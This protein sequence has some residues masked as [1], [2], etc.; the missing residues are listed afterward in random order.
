MLEKFATL[1]SA[2]SVLKIIILERFST[3]GIEISSKTA[4]ETFY[5]DGKNTSIA[6]KYVATYVCVYIYSGTFI[7]FL[8]IRLACDV[9]PCNRLPS[10][11]IDF[12]SQS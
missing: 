5:F 11:T 1:L 9:T 6:E 4:V 10:S 2:I 8:K 7:D 12:V 3:V